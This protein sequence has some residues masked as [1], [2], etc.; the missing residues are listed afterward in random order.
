VTPNSAIHQIAAKSTSQPNHPF[1][2]AP[3]PSD[4]H[5]AEDAVI[6]SEIEQLPDL[7]AFLKVASQP[8]WRRVQLN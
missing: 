1:W 5:T 6:A 7:T 4:H 2:G 3:P 8:Q